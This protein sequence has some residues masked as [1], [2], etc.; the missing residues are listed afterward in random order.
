MCKKWSI[1]EK[2]LGNVKLKIFGG[3]D[4]NIIV[5]G[6]MVAVLKAATK[7]MPVYVQYRAAN[8]PTYG[9]SFTSGYPYANKS[10]AFE[11]TCNSGFAPLKG[12]S[13]SFKLEYPNSYYVNMGTKLV[14]PQVKIM[15]CDANKVP[16]S[17]I[18]VVQVGNGIPYRSLT[19]PQKRNWLKGPMFYCNNNLPVR[20]QQT[21]LKNSGYPCTNKEAPNFWGLK[22]PC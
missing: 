18:Y 21:I 4:G 19:W 16:I 7:G 10:M 12:G 9:Q 6:N 17:D 15:F 11:G 1:I 13:F 20:D 5:T 8:K 3:N 22:P 2:D 14:P